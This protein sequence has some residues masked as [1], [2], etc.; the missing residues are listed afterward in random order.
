MLPV[1]GR[2][3]PGGGFDTS[4]KDSIDHKRN[5]AEYSDEGEVG[6]A[7]YSKARLTS[8]GGIT[9]EAT[10]LIRAAA[11]RYTFAPGTAS[12]HVLLNLGQANERHS[13]IGGEVKV[14]AKRS[15]EGRIVTRSFCGGANYTT[16]FRIVFDQP[17]ERGFVK[18]VNWAG[19]PLSR[20]G[21]DW[22]QLQAA[23]TLTYQ[24]A[25]AARRG[26]VG[27]AQPRLAAS[28]RRHRAVRHTLHTP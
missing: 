12:G 4:K 13:V 24:L 15:V 22:E 20:V 10:A 11:E 5:A 2:I 17:G 28:A 18:P 27:H 14:V 7:G 3:G 1:T 23:G 9:A 26:R 16:W 6:Q 19:R 25:P 21:L 8:S